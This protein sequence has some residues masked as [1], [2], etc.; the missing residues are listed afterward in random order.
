LKPHWPGPAIV[1]GPGS[2]QWIIRPAQRLLGGHWGALGELGRGTCNAVHVSDVAAACLA[3]I[4][5]PAIAGG[6]DTFNISGRETIS[7]SGWYARLAAALG[8]PTLRD[9]SPSRWRRRVVAALPFKVLA[10][11]SPGAGRV[12]EQRILAAPSPSEL[13]LFA[14][15]ATYPT[16]KAA[17]GLGWQPC[18]GLDEGL[19]NSVAWLRS[20]GLTR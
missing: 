8:C 11:L 5:A 6:V 4:R 1:Y 18:V 17:A 7:W 13:T 15:V 20:V 16:G 12:F 19:A 14:L 9:I 3:A 10:R 2:L